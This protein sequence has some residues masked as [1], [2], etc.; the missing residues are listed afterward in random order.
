MSWLRFRTPGVPLLPEDV[1]RRL[2]R[3]GA[4][5]DLLRRAVVEPVGA[6]AVSG[7]R[8]AMQPGAPLGDGAIA[9]GS[10]LCASLRP[11]RRFREPEQGPVV[12]RLPWVPW[13]DGEAAGWSFTRR[14]ERDG[15]VEWHAA[16]ST[17][18]ALSDLLDWTAA[19]G[20]P[21][22]GD[23]RRGGVLVEGGLCVAPAAS[24]PPPWPDEPVFAPEGAPL[25][26]SKATRLA[27]QRGHPWVLADPQLGDLRAFPPGWQVT[28]RDPGGS[29]AGLAR[30]DGE[31]RLA[32]RR[33]DLGAFGTA[34]VEARVDRAL[35][36]REAFL[37]A[38]GDEAGT[39]A[40]RLIHG[41]AD[42]L[43]GLAVDRFGGVLRIL[44]T[45]RAGLG[46]R[47]AV[48]A[49]LAAGAAGLPAGLPQI[50]VLHLRRPDDARLRSV[51][52]SPEFAPTETPIVREAG[53]AFG[54]DLGLTEP[55]RPRP[56]VGLFLDQRDNRARVRAHA[57]GG[58]F[59][60]LFA[61]T[62]SFS[63]ALLAGGAEA[64]WSVDLSAPY[65]AE[66]EANLARAGLQDRTHHSVRGEA[67]RFL[68]SGEGPAGFDG[69]V[70]DPPTAAAAGRQYWSV[71]RDLEPLLVAALQR[72]AP[73]GWLLVTRNDRSP[74]QE[75]GA[76]ADQAAARAGV[77]LQS[78]EE[79]PPSRDFPRLS[80]FPEGDA[81]E[82]IFLRAAGR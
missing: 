29:G 13:A 44:V 34:T 55:F 52:A 56:G 11:V 74:R 72:V 69:I 20:A 33:W 43:P 54:I 37:S 35:A 4:D 18:A 36:R 15:V 1:L 79:A 48:A 23:V 19:Q 68:D 27:L 61:H 24:E 26:V 21:V 5:P 10:A 16:S 17:G 63:V 40:Y 51:S 65:L 53:L 28:L 6:G 75:L 80:H 50:E 66:L 46:V 31:G 32:A 58:R 14:D 3:A 73:G 42:G 60:N 2:G 41:E 49:R 67:R 39:D 47:A 45:G 71:R 62:G 59:A 25:A 9:P 57:A 7:E 81:F 70:I 22:L 64:V 38:H 30:V 76:L 12:L 78:R 82:G 77:E 8:A